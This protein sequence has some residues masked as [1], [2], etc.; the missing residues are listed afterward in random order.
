MCRT[1]K[2]RWAKI[3]DMRRAAV[4][5]RFS[6]WK[7]SCKGC[8][9]EACSQLYIAASLHLQMLWSVSHSHLWSL[10]TL[11]LSLSILYTIFFGT[12]CFIWVRKIYFCVAGATL[13]LQ[14]FKQKTMKNRDPWIAICAIF[15][16]LGENCQKLQLGEEEKVYA[17]FG[18]KQL[19]LNWLYYIQSTIK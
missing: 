11:P 6:T 18:K 14:Q 5:W 13:Q 7:Y 9:Y 10:P 4:H 2:H 3:S 12:T 17:G 16:W 15:N 19:C 8:G 1:W